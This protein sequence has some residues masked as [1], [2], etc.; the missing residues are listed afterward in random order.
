MLVDELTGS[1]TGLSTRAK[2]GGI[3]ASETAHEVLLLAGTLLV[4][5]LLARLSHAVRP[6]LAVVLIVLV[7]AYA[8]R[9][10]HLGVSLYVLLFPFVDMLPKGFFGVVGLNPSNLMLVGLGLALLSRRT[11]GGDDRP[12]PL[13]GP[14]L[15]ALSAIY[16]LSVIAVFV[17]WNNGVPLM[18]G[19]D[20]LRKFF[21][22]TIPLLLGAAVFRQGRRAR[23]FTLGAVAGSVLIIVTWGFIGSGMG[24]V[25][26]RAR[27][28]GRIGQPNSY[29]AFLAL[30]LPAM[31]ALAASGKK[32]WMRVVGGIGVFLCLINLVNATS[33]G[34]ILAAGVGALVLGALRHRLLVAVLLVAALVL[35]P[36]VL[37]QRVLNRFEGTFEGAEWTGGMDKSA[38]LRSEMYKFTP[39]AFAHHPVLG[40][41]IGS[42]A[43]TANELGRPRLAR[44][45]HSFYI[46]VVTEM[47]LVGAL[48]F[49]WL[50]LSIVRRLV[51]RLREEDEMERALAAS[52]LA[53]CAA[54][55]LICAFQKPFVDNERIVPFFFLVLGLSLGLA[56]A[57]AFSNA[58]AGRGKLSGN[59]G[60]A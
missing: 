12:K 41:G 1:P 30:A 36:A 10:F 46:K 5:A 32:L 55:V 45:P 48:M 14:V 33:R 51:R 59:G 34:S 47:G 13:A 27:A 16:A 2:K 38:W 7:L 4:F 19:S 58:L 29:G 11:G 17:G 56:P 6:A 35:G 31:I 24:I 20:L 9:S 53:S 15:L 18:R 22:V 52:L 57:R 3:W 42:F 39:R 25:T 23:V 26:E 49:V 44:S 40:G 8:L 28:T 50:F 54:L 60:L 21:A 37:P 43:Y